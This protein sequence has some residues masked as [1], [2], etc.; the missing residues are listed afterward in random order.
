MHDPALHLFVD[1]YH[2]RNRFG[3]TRVF[4][5]LRKRREPVVRDVPGRYAGWGTALREPG[6]DGRFRLWYQSV[7]NANHH[8]I[9]T[10]GV[11]GGGKELGYFPDRH[12][13][14]VE[15]HL[16]SVVSYAESGDGLFWECPEVGRVEWQGSTANNIVLDGAAAAGQFDGT[17]TNMDTPSVIRDADEPDADQR[18]KLVMHWETF[19]VWDNQVSNLDRSDQYMAKVWASRAKYLTTSP[20]GIAWDAPLERIKECAGS[21]D[22]SGV[23][24]DERNH[25]YWF[26]D[27]APIGFPGKGYRSAAYCVSEDLRH[28][29]DD[30]DMVFGPGEYEDYGRRFEHHGIVPF[31]YGDQDLCFLELSITGRPIASSIGSH[32]D[33]ERWQLMRGIDQPFL[34]LGPLGAPDSSIVAMTRNAPLR[35][36]D[37]LLFL[38]NG[39]EGRGG[40]ICAATLRLDGFAGLA[41]DERVT[42]RHATPA[43]L[44]THPLQVQ[45]ERLELN[46]EGAAGCRVA[47]LDG[48]ARA[49]PG[50]ELEACEPVDGDAVRAPVAWKG[51]T[52]L[53]ALVGRAVMVLIELAGGTLWSVRL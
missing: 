7:S 30:V 4:G 3:L 29:P 5:Q 36:G 52:D 21:G 39:R 1:D 6:P 2:I 33:G 45:A 25:R 42:L 41:V 8:E 35:I 19:H 9:A 13:D 46:L 43:L 44:I 16:M 26:A 37:E 23:S 51:R 22:Y 53:S 50:F 11:F 40:T 27:R 38:Y 17:L 47:L 31:N 18:Y 14:A 24:R 20:D 12:P 48:S 49:I 32:R 28:W 15:P 10:A 34:R